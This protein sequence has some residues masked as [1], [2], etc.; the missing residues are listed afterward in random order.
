M[1][2]RLALKVQ[3]IISGD[4]RSLAVSQFR[5]FTVRSRARSAETRQASNLRIRKK[6]VPPLFNDACISSPNCRLP[7]AGKYRDST[8]G[9]HGV[10]DGRRGG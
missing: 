9:A 3:L 7:A 1:G 6:A 4:A 5:Q 10:E 2:A 8:A